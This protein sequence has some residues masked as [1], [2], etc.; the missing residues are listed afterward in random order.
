M[1]TGWSLRTSSTNFRKGIAMI[2]G[3]LTTD[4]ILDIFTD[5][6]QNR[7]GRVTDTFHDGRRLFVRSLLAARCRRPAER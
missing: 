5:E 7:N 3:T 6:V 4:R 1:G 2:D